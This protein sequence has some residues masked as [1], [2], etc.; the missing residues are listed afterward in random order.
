MPGL[1]HESI[2]EEMRSL[3]RKLRTRAVDL[4]PCM[5]AEDLIEF[6]ETHAL[7]QVKSSTGMVVIR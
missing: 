4:E 7:R 6:E 5:D 3:R 1:T 2:N